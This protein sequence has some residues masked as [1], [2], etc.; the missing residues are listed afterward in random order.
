MLI[1][2]P[3]RTKRFA[4][5]RQVVPRVYLVYGEASVDV[6]S[7]IAAV[8]SARASRVWR[9]WGGRTEAEVRSCIVAQ[10]RR[11]LGVFVARELA[12]HRLHR[13]PLVG[14]SRDALDARRAWGAGP[15]GHGGGPV[16]GHEGAFAAQDFFALTQ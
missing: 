3:R 2:R 6:H 11:S 15:R 9:R 14:V 13:I 12:R 8:A 4:A 16:L 5:P 10:V 1:S 7:L